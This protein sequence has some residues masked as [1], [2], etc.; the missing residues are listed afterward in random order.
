MIQLEEGQFSLARRA[1]PSWKATT[2][3]AALFAR[4]IRPLLLP[5]LPLVAASP[6]EGTA[7]WWI[8]SAIGALQA[9]GGH[10]AT[11]GSE[12]DG[13]GGEFSYVSQQENISPSIHQIPFHLPTQSAVTDHKLV[14]K[15]V[16]LNCLK[17]ISQVCPFQL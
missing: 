14:A 1:S 2:T 8:S 4:P 16:V 13:G 5:V 15:R 17:F 7:A 11:V 6:P 10:N 3:M 12:A 9:G